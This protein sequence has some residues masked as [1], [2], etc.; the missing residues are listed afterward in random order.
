MLERELKAALRP[1]KAPLSLRERVEREINAGGVRPVLA[2]R[3]IATGV[4]LAAA[5]LS[6]VYFGAARAVAKPEPMRPAIERQAQQH[7]CR[8]CHTG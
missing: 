4:A 3:R 6:A 1:A 5:S 8:S 2:W 7:A